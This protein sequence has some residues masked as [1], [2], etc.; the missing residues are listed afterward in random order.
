LVGWLVGR[1]TTLFGTKI[2]YIRD[3]VSGADLVPLV[4]V[5]MEIRHPI[6]GPSGHEV[7]AFVIIAKLSWPEVARPGNFCEQF[8][9]FIG[10]I[11]PLKF[12]LPLK[13]S[14]LH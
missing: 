6:G 8:V 11:T 12:R 2:G 1:L 4:T 3:K 14:L 7:S 13:L 9:R 5:K 10:K